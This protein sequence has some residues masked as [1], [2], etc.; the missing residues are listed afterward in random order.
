MKFYELI[1]LCALCVS[2]FVLGVLFGES[3]KQVEIENRVLKVVKN[4]S[5]PII[6]TQKEL[7]I[8]IFNK[9]QE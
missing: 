1:I 7:E 4:K 3:N 9:I 8:I 5:K 2:L 6:Y